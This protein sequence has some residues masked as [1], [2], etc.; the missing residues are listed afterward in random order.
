MEAGCL[1]VEL[2]E[3]QVVIAL[4][5][6]FSCGVNELPLSMVLSWFEQKAVAILLSLLYMGVRGIRLGASL[7]AFMTDDVLKV[8]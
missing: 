8:L 4:V 3:Y 1:P 7:P 6:A 5:K 2:S